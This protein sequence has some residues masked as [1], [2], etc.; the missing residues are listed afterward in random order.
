MIP[1]IIHQTYKD[2]NLPDLFKQCQT[3]IK[4][5]CSDFIYKFYNDEVFLMFKKQI[6]HNLSHTINFKNYPVINNILK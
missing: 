2:T 5:V 1:K 4:N 6:K 3:Q